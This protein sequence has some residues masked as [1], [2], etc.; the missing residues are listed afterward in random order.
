MSPAT[1][2]MTN[3]LLSL[4]GTNQNMLLCDVD[5]TQS[6]AYISTNHDTLIRF[7]PDMFPLFWQVIS[8]E[9]TNF[10][11]HLVWHD[12]ESQTPPP[13]AYGDDV[14]LFQNNYC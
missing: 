11:L 2:F 7:I 12:R 4:G 9:S 13:I 10:T 8:G 5:N 6:V 1:N 3:K 14:Q